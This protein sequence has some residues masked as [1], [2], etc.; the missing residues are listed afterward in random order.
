M[1]GLTQG[2]FDGDLRRDQ[3]SS[4]ALGTVLPEYRNIENVTTSHPDF[5][6]LY[7]DAYHDCVSVLKGIQQDGLGSTYRNQVPGVK[8]SFF[9]N[10]GICF[11]NLARNNATPTQSVGLVFCLA[12]N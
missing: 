6:M 5:L 10:Y 7:E 8:G 3:R 4:N 11:M 12:E 2:K 1:H 9:Q